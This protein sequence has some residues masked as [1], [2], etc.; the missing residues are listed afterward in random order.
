MIRADDTLSLALTGDRQ[1]VVTV[2]PGTSACLRIRPVVDKSL[3]EKVFDKGLME[4]AVGTIPGEPGEL[5]VFEGAALQIEAMTKGV[6]PVA[7][8]ALQV[9]PDG[10]AR[11]YRLVRRAAV[12]AAW[13]AI[14]FATV[15]TQ[16]WRPTGRPIYNGKTPQR[17][18]DTGDG[19]VVH[20][21]PNGDFDGF[22]DEVFDRDRDD[23]N[24]SSPVRPAPV[25]HVAELQRFDWPAP[26]ATL[27]RHRVTVQSR[28]AGA[29]VLPGAGR[30]AMSGTGRDATVAVLADA[31]R[32]RMPRPQVRAFLPLTGRVGGPGAGDPVGAT[33]CRRW[34]GRADQR[35]PDCGAGAC[36]GGRH[37]ESCGGSPRS[38]AVQ[39]TGF[40][41]HRGGGVARSPA[42]H[43]R[44]HRPSLRIPAGAQ[45]GLREQRG[46]DPPGTPG[47]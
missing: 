37:S 6:P 11:G 36:H 7:R 13:K 19:P 22:A 42:A 26:S 41:A 16:R 43:R 17:L 38:R 25:G 32:V 21:A 8:D 5:V 39:G 30:L 35:R 47:R 46:A 14:A 33:L 10:A 34:A 45:P 31:A 29:M 9:L 3:F 18:T 4:W 24:P 27:F 20:C 23:A 44:P 12:A 2:P 28:Y 40:R 15:H 1:F